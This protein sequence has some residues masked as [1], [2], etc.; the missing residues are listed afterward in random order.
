M[1]E[2]A[3]I[4]FKDAS[5]SDDAVAVVRYDDKIVAITLSVLSGSD[6]DVAM[7]KADAR[8]FL[9]ALKVAVA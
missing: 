1:K 2:V 5:T 8:A 3:T 7:S 6:V 9:E 4:L